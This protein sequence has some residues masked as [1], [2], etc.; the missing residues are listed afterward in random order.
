MLNDCGDD[1]EPSGIARLV[2]F[3]GQMTC[4]GTGIIYFADI[5]KLAITTY[6]VIMKSQILLLVAKSYW[7]NLC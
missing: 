3:I 7:K 5:R 2:Y 1:S 4:K 6:K